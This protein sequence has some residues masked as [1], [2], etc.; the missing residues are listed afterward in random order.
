MWEMNNVYK[1]FVGKSEENRNDL[2]ILV[3][4][5]RFT[6]R[7]NLNWVKTGFISLMIRPCGLHL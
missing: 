5:G 1:L 6:L 2:E 3:K 4:Y 7:R